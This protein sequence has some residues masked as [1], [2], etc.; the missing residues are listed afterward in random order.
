MYLAL[1]RHVLWLHTLVWH[2]LNDRT[3]LSDLENP[4]QWLNQMAGQARAQIRPRSCICISACHGAQ[5]CEPTASRETSFVGIRLDSLRLLIAFS[6][7]TGIRPNLFYVT[8]TCTI[9]TGILSTA[10]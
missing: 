10:E 9:E 2:C 3:R 6:G 7:K 8:I 1:F 4:K 5:D